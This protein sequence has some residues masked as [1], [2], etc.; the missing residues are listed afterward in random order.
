MRPLP[1]RPQNTSR[2]PA[3]LTS[4]AQKPDISYSRLASTE[5][6]VLAVPPA[7]RFAGTEIE[8]GML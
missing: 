2:D 3:G 8:V 6:C 4:S 1:G 5:A 7:R